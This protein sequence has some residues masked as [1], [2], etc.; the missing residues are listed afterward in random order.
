MRCCF[1]IFFCNEF[2]FASEYSYQKV[3]VLNIK[4]SIIEIEKGGIVYNKINKVIGTNISALRRSMNLKQEAF[5][6]ELNSMLKRKYNINATYDFKTISKWEMGKSIP[7]L[8]VLIAISKEYNLSL[9]ELLKDNIE[10]VVE[11]SN[12]SNSEENLLNEF[13]KN[14]AVCTLENGKLVSAFNPKMY[15]YGQLSYL[16][17]NL[18]EYRSNYS[19]NFS[20]TNAT[21]EVEIIVGIMDVNDGKRELHYLGNGENDIVSIE[22]VPLDFEVK[23]NKNNIIKEMYYHEL[24]NDNN[25]EIIKLGNGKS[26]MLNENF[27]KY[28]SSLYKFTKDDMPQDLDYYGVDK[29]EGDWTDYACLKGHYIIDDVNLFEFE[30]SGIYYYKNAGIFVVVLYGKI[31]C[32]DAQL[33][34]VLS[35]DY[36]HRLIN[37]LQEITDESICNKSIEEIEKYLEYRKKEKLN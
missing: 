19:K 9:D 8:D 7:R 33:V 32:N 30:G 36:K 4:V 24:L 34:K 16:A 15:K 22:K 20:F 6:M 3:V 28:D 17:D 29:N 18:V 23:T 25:I 31:K 14:P 37:A 2:A 26:F 27:S 13:I 35:D 11:K 10:D 1:L 21:K 5:A 12:F